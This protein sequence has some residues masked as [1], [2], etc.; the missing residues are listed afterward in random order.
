MRCKKRRLHHNR[1]RAVRSLSGD[2]AGLRFSLPKRFVQT[3]SKRNVV[4]TKNYK[5][6]DN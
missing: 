2:M 6:Y 5:N 4:Q 3:S 1:Y